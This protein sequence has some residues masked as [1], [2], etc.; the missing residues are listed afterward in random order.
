MLTYGTDDNVDVIIWSVIEAF[1]AIICA[2]LMCFRPLLVR[3]LPSLFQATKV[4]ESRYAPN[5]SWAQV[6]SSKLSSKLRTGNNGVELHSE[7]DQRG[8]QEKA[9]RV[10]KTWTTETSI[11]LQDHR[12]PAERGNVAGGSVR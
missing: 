9:I 2:C 10:Q 6:M 12:R 3:L 11:E 1:T 8:G 7:D 4:G 5:P